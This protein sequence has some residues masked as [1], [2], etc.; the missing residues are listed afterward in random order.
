[1]EARAAGVEMAMLLA[2]ILLWPAV[3]GERHRNP[4]AAAGEEGAPACLM[5]LRS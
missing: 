1:M 4:A 3:R 5:S 2:A